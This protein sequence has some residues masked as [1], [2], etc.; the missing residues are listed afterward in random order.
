MR[1]KSEL[2][3]TDDNGHSEFDD[4]VDHDDDSDDNCDAV[5]DDNIDERDV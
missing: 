3:D 1:G 4:V 5:E 2:G